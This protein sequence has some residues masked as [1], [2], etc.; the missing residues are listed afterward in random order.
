MR[1]LVGVLGIR[2]SELKHTIGITKLN[3]LERGHAPAGVL[4]RDAVG[5]LKG[6]PRIRHHVSHCV[7]PP[8]AAIVSL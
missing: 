5:V 1:Q 8:A 6:R 2:L 4:G 3:N 7:A